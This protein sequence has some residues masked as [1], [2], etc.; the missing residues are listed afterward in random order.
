VTTGVRVARAEAVIVADED[1]RYGPEALAAMLQTLG[2]ADLVIP[3]NVFEPAPWH[4]RWDMARSLINLAVGSDYP[5]TMG[6]R[7]SSFFSIG[8]YDGNVLFEN[9]E[10]WRT[11]RAHGGQIVQAPWI[12]VDRRPPTAATF[13]RQRVR[14]AYDDLAQPPRLIAALTV[15]PL[16]GTAWRR[17]RVLLAAAACGAIGIAELGRRRAHLRSVVPAR[18]DLFAPA[19]VLERGI[20]SWLAIAARVFLGGCPYR[21]VRFERAATPLSTLIGRAQ[22]SVSVARAGAAC[23]PSHSGRSLER[24]HLHSAI[25]ARRESTTSPSSETTSTGP[26]TRNGPP[27]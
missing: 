18:V 25:V 3:L 17:S 8:G 11:V 10:L 16:A 19:W 9:L 12:V 13:F 24:P 1:V 21:G 20:C 6:I 27:A 5:G 4:A 23:E 15:L 14:Q 22:S 26:R 2:H 7:R